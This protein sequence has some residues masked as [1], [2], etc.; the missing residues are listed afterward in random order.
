MCR[1][2]ADRIRVVLDTLNTHT[3]A[4][5]CETFLPPRPTVSA[6]ARTLPSTGSSPYTTLVPSS[7]AF[8][9]LFLI[10]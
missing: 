2:K 9:L 6:I 3:V 10:D 5:L 4:A 1:T 7:S 8:I